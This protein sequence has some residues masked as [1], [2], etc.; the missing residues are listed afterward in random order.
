M[1]KAKIIDTFIFKAFASVVLRNQLE[2][3][4]LHKSPSLLRKID[5]CRNHLL[6]PMPDQRSDW[7]EPSSSTTSQKD[8]EVMV[9]GA[10]KLLKDLQRINETECPVLENIE[11]PKVNGQK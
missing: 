2:N 5:E 11:V 9:K 7:E 4:L 10:D 8:E 1:N 3:H 6:E